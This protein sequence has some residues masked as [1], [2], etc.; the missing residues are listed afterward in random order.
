MQFPLAPGYYVYLLTD[1]SPSRHRV[2]LVKGNS[3]VA[4]VNID[5]PG[6]PSPVEINTDT[7][8]R[9]G[10]AVDRNT[11]MVWVVSSSQTVVSGYRVRTE[12]LP[13]SSSFVAVPAYAN[14]NFNA[15]GGAGI[16]GTPSSSILNRVAVSGNL[17][18]ASGILSGSG[19]YQP[20]S[21][22][23]YINVTATDATLL[24]AQTPFTDLD[25]TRTCQ[26]AGYQ[27]AIEDV[28]PFQ[29]NGN[30]FASLSL[31]VDFE[32]V[33]IDSGCMAPTEPDAGAQD[34]GTEPDGGGGSDAG[35]DHDGGTAIGDG[36]EGPAAI[37][38]GCGCKTSSASQVPAL[39]FLIAA[40]F[41]VKRRR[42]A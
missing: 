25:P 3:A 27:E 36:G 32:V 14:L 34:S 37:G 35:I 38:G 11:G 1:N 7:G 21:R 23:G 22:I 29:V 10:W 15:S 42:G 39:A 17:V 2:L 26:N 30:Y 16:H 6:A 12:N 33:A 20:N 4:V 9:G 40:C 41:G 8:L 19:T 24:P 18:V 28:R 13:A 5:N 31:T